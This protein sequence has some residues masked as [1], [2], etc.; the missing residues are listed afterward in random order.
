MFATNKVCTTL[1][2]LIYS[3]FGSRTKDFE[4]HSISRLLHVPHIPVVGQNVNSQDKDDLVLG[5]QKRAE[6][7]IFE[8]HFKIEE[9]WKAK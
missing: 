3:L 2:Y 6:K 7:G 4:W 5:E 1:D 9:D 8:C